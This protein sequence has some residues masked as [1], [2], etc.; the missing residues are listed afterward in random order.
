MPPRVWFLS[1]SHPCQNTDKSPYVTLAEPKV[2]LRKAGLGMITC[3]LQVKGNGLFVSQ[4]SLRPSR[5]NSGFLVRVSSSGF[6]GLSVCL[7]RNYEKTCVKRTTGTELTNTLMISQEIFFLFIS[8]FH[9]SESI[10]VICC[11]TKSE[12]ST[13]VHLVKVMIANL[14][15]FV[16]LASINDFCCVA[17]NMLTSKTIY[18]YLC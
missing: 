10:T 15:H 18:S 13:I 2:E 7:S 12:F 16:F 3:M 17:S 14:L 4:A 6:E 8:I 1:L 5:E 11:C 9:I